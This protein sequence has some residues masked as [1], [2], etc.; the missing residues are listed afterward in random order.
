MRKKVSDSDQASAE[1]GL[2]VVHG[3]LGFRSPYPDT[4]GPPP[5]PEVRE[6]TRAAAPLAQARP[7]FRY[8]AENE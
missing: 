1:E 3:H 5:P 2:V 8:R 4:P 7:S 6:S